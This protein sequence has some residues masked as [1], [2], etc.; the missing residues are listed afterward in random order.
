MAERIT[1]R[2]LPNALSYPDRKRVCGL[3]GEQFLN[4][5][6]APRVF[7]CATLEWYKSVDL[8]TGCEWMHASPEHYRAAL[9]SKKTI[10]IVQNFQSH[11]Y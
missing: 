7:L 1:E 4:A 8:K 11:D 6:R 9:C 2:L 5:S 3:P 10:K